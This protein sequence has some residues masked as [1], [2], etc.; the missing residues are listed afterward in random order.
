MKA[1]LEVGTVKMPADT[2]LEDVKV[3]VVLFQDFDGGRD[4]ELQARLSFTVSEG[5]VVLW[6][7]QEKETHLL[8][9]EQFAFKTVA[10]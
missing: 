6:P 4:P 10:R 8:P 7:G 3:E 9:K 1:K 2:T 5:E